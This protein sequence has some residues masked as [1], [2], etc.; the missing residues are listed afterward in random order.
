MISFSDGGGTKRLASVIIPESVKNIGDYAFY[1][2]SNLKNFYYNGSS[3]QWDEVVKGEF[4]DS[5]TPNYVIHFS[6][7]TTKTKN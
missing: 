2:C 1:Y 6:D 7:G 5:G 3:S 4:W